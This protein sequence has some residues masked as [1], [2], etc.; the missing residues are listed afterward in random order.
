MKITLIIFLTV[1]FAENIIGYQNPDEFLFN[2]LINSN[3]DSLTLPVQLIY[4]YATVQPKNVLLKWGT[5]TEVNNY[6]FEVERSYVSTENWQMV[7]F[8]LGSGTSN[9]PINYEYADTSVLMEGKV[10]YRLKQID[11]VGGFVYSDTI[12]VTFPTFVNM[13][14]SMVPNNFEVSNNYPNPFNPATKINISIPSELVIKISIYNSLGM[15]VK[16]FNP[17]E[18]LPGNYQ[19]L[20]D[21]TGYSSGIYFVRF[22]SQKNIITKQITFTK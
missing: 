20:F 11:I 8:V 15:L 9:I 19:L 22:N 7:D 10:Y 13:E 5:A 18:F 16:D 2:Q 17:K 6:G 12:D 4:F 1:L 14:K 3:K 21:F